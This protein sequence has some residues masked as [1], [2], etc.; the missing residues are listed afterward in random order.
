MA[1]QNEA[2][3]QLTTV[4]AGRESR[5]ARRKVSKSLRP[6][7]DLRF[8]QVPAGARDGIPQN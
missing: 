5:T 6:T 2:S 4:V 7:A 3:K 1:F 8:A